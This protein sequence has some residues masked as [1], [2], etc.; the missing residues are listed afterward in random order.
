MNDERLRALYAGAMQRLPAPEDAEPV[1]LDAMVDVLER[2]GSEAERSRTLRAVLRDPRAH[3]E[4]ELLRAV[5]RASDPPRRSWK[6]AAAWRVAAAVTIMA[7]T[8][9]IF[10]QTRDA[11]DQ[12]R[13]G[14]ATVTTVQPADGVELTAPPLFAWHQ[15][16]EAVDYRIEILDSTGTVVF[17]EQGGDTVSTGPVSG[18]LVPGNRYR[19]SV[20]AVTKDAR[21]LRS[22]TQSFTYRAP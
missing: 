16:P 1:S 4:F 9:W 5:V 6:T 7:G 21:S 14:T 20:T 8:A 10:R 3:E 13:G 22:A 15:V 12:L 11:G 2:R 17:E 18:S 19:W